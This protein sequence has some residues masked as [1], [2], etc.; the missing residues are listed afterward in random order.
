MAG[1]VTR[2]E[3]RKTEQNF[4]GGRPTFKT[5]KEMGG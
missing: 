1:H 4:G 5:E 2:M 3:I